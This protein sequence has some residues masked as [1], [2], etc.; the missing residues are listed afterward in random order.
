MPERRGAEKS[1]AS[2]AV[3]KKIKILK[4]DTQMAEITYSKLAQTLG[5]AMIDDA[6]R[7]KLL[8]D[9]K[10]M[11]KELGLNDTG[12]EILSKLDRELLASFTGRLGTKLLQDGAVVIFCG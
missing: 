8:K 2:V 1:A 12:I 6:F 4:G 5:R 11:G 7:E 9:P 10:A 3:S